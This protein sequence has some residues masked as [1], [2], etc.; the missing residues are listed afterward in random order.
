MSGRFRVLAAAMAA[1]YAGAPALAQQGEAV[2]REVTV[3]GTAEETLKQA[4]G[5]SIITAEDIGKRP[6]VN[7]ISEIIRTMPG[8]NLTGNSTSGQRGNNRQI[9]L[10]G[11]GPENTLILI[12]GK[13]AT[14]RNSVRFGWRGERD[15]R[16]DSNWVP[17]E[18]IERI[19]VIRG[20]AAARYGNGAA[21]G[22]VNIITKK[23]GKELHGEVSLYANAPEH[24]DEGATRR[25]NFGLSG[26]L[27]EQ[28]SFRVMGNYN[29]TEED[30]RYIND[31]H[32][33][34]GFANAMP[35]GREGV[36]NRDFSGQLSWQP[37][38]AH[39]LDLDLGY[40]RQ[41]NL[42]AGDTQN[43]SSN[44][45]VDPVVER[46]RGKE[47]NVMR[48]TNYALTH[49][50]KYDFG[51]SLSYV[52]YTA[53][54]NKR[55]QEGLAGATEGAFLAG[56]PPFMTNELRDLTVHGEVNLPLSGVFK[57]VLTVGAEWTR[58]ELE[59]PTSTTQTTQFGTIP[60][61]SSTGRSPDA[62]ARIASV[63]VEDN[64]ELSENTV[65]T[66]GLRFDRHS[67]AGGNWSPAL[68]LMHMFSD[69]V[70]LKGG[71]ARAYKAPNLY[72]GNP[73]YL[74]YSNGNGCPTVGNGTTGC[75]LIG[76][77][78]LDAETSINKELGIEYKVGGFSAGVTWFRNDYRDKIQADTTPVGITATGN[79]SIYQWTNIPK[80]VVE[81]LEGSLRLPLATGL[82][83]LTN[84]TYMIES[85]NKTTG[86]Y[87][88]I[89]PEYTVNTSLDWRASDKFGLLLAV[90]FYGEQEPM[91][92]DFKG[93]RVTGTSADSVDPYAVVNLSGDYAVSKHLK[94]TAGINNLFDKRQ[95]RRG[96]AVSV[97]STPVYG[98]SG[99]AGAATYNEHG[100]TLY[101]A[102][103]TSF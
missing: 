89:I 9:D 95:Y 39:R 69:R 72:Q 93:D 86:D 56:N 28:F 49:T 38:A 22:V 34:P 7:D 97:S 24:S 33:A 44:P 42:Y 81:G 83:W 100:R 87:L 80:A 52:Q 53:T 99:G 65:L 21:G 59:D 78:D 10:R 51:S 103:T 19:E 74:L 67:E 17:A 94:V 32:Q 16:G 96:N 92:Y 76:N 101:V 55:I 54:D 62:S 91:K 90:T 50:G 20:P 15:T 75:Y 23:A 27:G 43:A 18:Q 47:T 26:P 102:L 30:D 3:L 71:I 12:D 40:S 4:P 84:F 66:P 8:V 70:T 13:P 45:V 82:D 61:V 77:D 85:K 57:Q 31:G 6:P 68:N 37:S 63:F 48:R 60:G 29:R 88:S 36:N 79:R 64:I 11:M 35:A 2:L 98:T 25:L 1:A 58:S 46:M 73:N 5:V 41:G 14:S